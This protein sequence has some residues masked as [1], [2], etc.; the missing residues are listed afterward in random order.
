[1]IE[2]RIASEGNSRLAVRRSMINVRARPA[3]Q[4]SEERFSGV[5]RGFTGPGEG[6]VG[7]PRGNETR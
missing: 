4:A 7:L 2:T 6:L 5:L 1:M 3:S